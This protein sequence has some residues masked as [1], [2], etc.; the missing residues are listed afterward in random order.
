MTAI[1][2]AGLLLAALF[3]ASCGMLP[4]ADG[5]PARPPP[6]L[7]AVP[8]AVP[9][10]EPPIPHANPPFYEVDGVRYRVLPSAEGYVARGLASW[11][12]TKF[13]GRPTSSGEPYD[14]YAMTAAHRTL[15]IP[16]YVEVTNLENGRRVVVRINDRGPFVPGRIIDLSYAAAVKLGMVERG[17]A[18]VEV[19]AL[20]PRPQGLYLQVGAFA[21]PEGAERLRLR[22]LRVLPAARV[23]RLPPGPDGLHR[24]R[25]GPLRDPEEAETLA[26][27][28][29]A[30][31]VPP[32]HLV[33]EGGEASGR[34]RAV[35]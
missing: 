12:G 9:R 33:L 20:S 25:I 13:H 16:S 34:G 8:D 5:P 32:G 14:M 2:R 26:R 35:Q 22:L 18:P 7:A 19:R 27:R 3:L 21:R 6:D 24:V 17:T 28:L 29:A 31:Q 10:D 4:V 11:Y 30:L 23:H 15:P 1:T